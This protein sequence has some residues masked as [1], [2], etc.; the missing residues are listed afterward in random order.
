VTNAGGA[1]VVAL[2][3][4]GLTKLPFEAVSLPTQSTLRE[5][6]PPAS[7]V[8]NPVD[9]LGD[10]G[11][12]RYARACR[13]IALTEQFGAMLVILTPQVNTE[14]EET[15]KMLVN[16]ANDNQGNPVLPVFIGGQKL[17][18]AIQIFKQA[19]LPY[20]D[21][22]EQALLALNNLANFSYINTKDLSFLEAP[23]KVLSES[24]NAEIANILQSA[25]KDGLPSLDFIGVTRI[26]QL[27][28]LPMPKF[29]LFDAGVEKEQ[30]EA[31]FTKD[32]FKNGVVLKV[33]SASELHRTDK[34]MVEV[35]VKTVDKVIEFIQEFNGEQIL[36]Q[37]LAPKGVEVFLGIK[38]DP[39]FGQVLVVGSGG[40]YAEVWKDFALGALPIT[41]EKIKK[42]FEMTKIWKI[43][44]GFR[45]KNYDT[46]TLIEVTYN[47]TKLALE[48]PEISSLDMNPVIVLESGAVVVDLKVL[49]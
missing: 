1:G 21:S 44:N 24:E 37:Q 34:G 49:V 26:S 8:H 18:S 20:F 11:V 15:A 12:D 45:G 29:E 36:V 19:K 46:D 39:Q 3:G 7:N 22:P 28:G 17:D 38:N 23:Q 10:A 6:L 27:F 32:E 30:I 47:L 33:V 41:R 25:K 13:E 16:L 4:F 31:I 14:I 43:L 35:G 2:D 5:L 42:I 40:I 9:V 48:F